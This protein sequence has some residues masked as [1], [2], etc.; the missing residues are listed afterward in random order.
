M[1]EEESA[2]S[3]TSARSE[4]GEG[5]KK[6]CFERRQRPKSFLFSFFSLPSFFLSSSLFSSS[7]RPL[8]PLAAPRERAPTQRER[9]RRYTVAPANEERTREREGDNRRAKKMEGANDDAGIADATA[10][11]AAPPAPPAAAPAPP[12]ATVSDEAIATLMA[13]TG[14]DEAS[15]RA[16][17]EV[18]EE[19]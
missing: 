1:S 15:A 16:L 4:R 14:G 9:G 10:A 12:A 7:P 3:K 19:K 6:M 11:A 18:R 2:D 13:L 17:L 8:S 5:K